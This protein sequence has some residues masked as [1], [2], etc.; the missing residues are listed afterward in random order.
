MIYY[1]YPVKKIG[2][3]SDY[4]FRTGA[5]AGFHYGLDLGWFDYQGEEIYSIGEGEVIEKGFTNSA[6][7]YI[8]IKHS[9]SDKSSYLHLR[10]PSYLNV[11][12]IVSTGTLLGY[13]GTT[14]NSTGVHLHISFTRDGNY[15]DPKTILYVYNDQIVSNTTKNNYTLLYYNPIVIN[16]VERDVNKNQ[17]SV[18]IT[19]LNIRKGPGTS[20]ERYPSYINTGIYDFYEVIDNEGYT[21]YKIGEEAFIAFNEEWL[22]IYHKE[23][24]SELEK[25]KKELDEKSEILNKILNDYKFKYAVTKTG[26]YKIELKSGEYLIIK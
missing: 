20:Y 1:K 14:G 16:S 18:N 2:I 13:M 5:K 6:G 24:L 11:G 26:K 25:L 19:D 22:T 15:I 8:T 10:E 12:D 3:T 7:N 4:G 21:W 9:S 17:L 23:E